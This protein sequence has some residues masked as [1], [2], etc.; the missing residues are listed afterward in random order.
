MRH[1]LVA[2]VVAYTFDGDEIRANQKR[3]NTRRLIPSRAPATTS[4]RVRDTTANTRRCAGSHRVHRRPT[5]AR[6]AARAA[7]RPHRD[8]DRARRYTVDSKRSRRIARRR[9]HRTSRLGQSSHCEVRGDPR[10]LARPRARRHSHPSRARSHAAARSQARARS[11]PSPCRDRRRTPRDPARCV[12]SAS[13]T[14]RSVSGRGISTAGDTARSSFQNSRWPT[15]YA[16]GSP[17]ARASTA[18]SKRSRAPASG[19]SSGHAYSFARETPSV[20]E[21]QLGLEPRAVAA[22]S[23]ARAREQFAYVHGVGGGATAFGM[24]TAAFGRV[25][26]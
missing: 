16:T 7:D 25:R 10:S 3:A 5:Q 26:Q 4:R 1:A 21:Q 13:S 24:S 8:A 19:T 11:R 14:R 15:R 2:C 22:K 17:P 12:S 20:C 23:S 9:A 6:S 18:R